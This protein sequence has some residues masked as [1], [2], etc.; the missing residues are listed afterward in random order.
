VTGG[1]DVSETVRHRNVLR[2]PHADGPTRLAAVE[3]GLI[4]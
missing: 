1:L 2:N 3:R 4:G